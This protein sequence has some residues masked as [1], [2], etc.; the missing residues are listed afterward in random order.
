MVA[1]V[2]RVANQMLQVAWFRD[3]LRDE[4]APYSGREALVA[5]MVTVST[6]VMVITMTFR[7]PYGT[8][9][10]FYALTISRAS[11]QSTKDA[12]TT[13]AVVIAVAATYM[14]IGGLA[15]QGDPML[16]LL[17][18]I[19]TF[20]AMFFAISTITNY[21]A[22]TAFGFLIA[23]TIP[24]WDLPVPPELKVEHTLWTAGQVI[25][26]CVVT[27]AIEL[28]FAAWISRDD[29]LEDLANCLTAVEEFLMKV[30]RGRPM[31]KAEQKLTRLRMLGTSRLRQLLQRSASSPSY[32]EQM[33]AVVALVGR[34]ID[35]AVDI[36]ELGVDVSQSDRERMR[37]VAE[38][39][40]GLRADL[41]LGRVPRRTE[42]PANREPSHVL[43]LVLELEGTVSLIPHAFAGTQSS[44]AQTLRQPTE[45]P[46]G[47]FRPDA[48]TNAEHVRFALKG[49]LAASLCYVIY[50]AVF[51]PGLN[52]AVFAC[53]LTAL[54]TVGASRHKQM[55][56]V[57]GTIAGGIV[58]I[59]AQVFILPHVDSIAGFTLLF[60][61]VTTAA[62]WVVTSGPRLSFVGTQ[63]A[64]AFYI[65]HVQEFM[66]QTSLAVA[67][68]RL[69]GILFGLFMMWIVFDQLWGAPSA[70][71]MKSQ[72]I[73]TLRLLAQLA[74]EPSLTDRRLALGRTYALRE[75][76]NQ[77]FDSVR[78]LAD[79]VLFEFGP[80][81]QRDLALRSRIRD[82][83]PQ[84]RIVFLTR[85]ALLKYRLNV[86]G[87]EL[88]QAIRQAQADFD[89]SLA[90]RLDGIAGRLAGTVSEGGDEFDDAFTRLEQVTRQHRS[91]QPHGELPV[92]L[93]SFL[94][95]SRRI[96]ALTLVLDREVRL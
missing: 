53:L 39:I 80:S 78:A 46:S 67:R 29:L 52:A 64:L 20:F 42:A 85:I 5:R 7:L 1:G 63:C 19:G 35:I 87:F 47:F 16:R 74:R 11:L 55:L 17:W 13:L 68:D 65:V 32:M 77:R 28:A 58:A 86:R 92:E 96:H 30:A 89:E 26:T 76:I 22:A 8:L 15:S 45:R 4:L 95:L 43:P 34:L 83:Q 18:I 14:T 66:M 24:L 75:T 59:G 94:N 81:R 23:F 36:A 49:C 2:A 37:R 79:G 3:F 70:V 61:V 38:S 21:A 48:F 73:S 62:T 71:A 50:K 51:W 27:L 31:G 84:L 6:V 90:R 88:P 56:M 60:V 10:A 41:L 33:G 40:A 57:A 72:V 93:G 91:E 44:G 9:S 25:I 82:W 54:T 69:A 12:T